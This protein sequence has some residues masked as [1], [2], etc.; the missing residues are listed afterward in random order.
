M[1]GSEGTLAMITE[2]TLRT[3]DLPK[4]KALL[5]LEF[6]S[7]ED[8]ARAVP[9]IV[10]SGAA[11]CEMMDEKLLEMAVDA[12]PQYADIFPEKTSRQV[13]QSC[14]GFLGKIVDCCKWNKGKSTRCREYQN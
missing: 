12:L 5:Q 4:V 11:A 1:A 10:E 3:V 13:R 14:I 8:T 7:I 6:S 9:L 2:I